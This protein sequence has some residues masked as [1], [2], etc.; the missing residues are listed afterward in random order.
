MSGRRFEDRLVILYL[1][2]F[3]WLAFLL[4][5]MRA[6]LASRLIISKAEA[7]NYDA[8]LRRFRAL[9][10][11]LTAPYSQYLE[12]F[13]R[14][15]AGR[16]AEA[17]PLYRE[18]LRKARTGTGFPC[19]P[20]YYSLGRALEDL[21]R[22]EE[23]VEFLNQ[24]IA[25]G[26]L[27]GSSYNALA[28]IGVAQ[29]RLAE[30]L[31]FSEQAVD[32]ACRRIKPQFLGIYHAVH[33]WIL[34][35][36]GRSGDARESLR[37]ALPGARHSA[38]NRAWLHWR[39]GLALVAL[40]QNE[41]AYEQ[42]CIGCKVDPRG[43]LGQRCLEELRKRGASTESKSSESAASG[44]RL[45]RAFAWARERKGSVAAALLI[46][47]AMV[48]C[49]LL[50][51]INP[52]PSPDFRDSGA[53]HRF[54][55]GR[56]IDLP[57]VRGGV[58]N[59]AVSP[60]GAIWAM[61]PSGQA[62]LRWDGDRW[63]RYS[64]AQFGA[65]KALGLALRDDEAWVATDDGIARFDGRNW[66]PDRTAP[67]TRA[68]AIAAGP[69]GV[70][71]IDRE[72]NLAHFDGIG[73]SLENLRST[74]AG[75]DWDERLEDG[76]LQLWV[77][78]DGGLWLLLGGLWRKDESGWRAYPVENVDWDSAVMLAHGGR[79][80]WL[81]TPG[82]IFE[83]TLN[84][85]LGELYEPRDLPIDREYGLFDV[86]QAEGKTWLATSK[87]LLT[88]EAGKWRHH[89]LPPGGTVVKE[90]AAA[91]DG[92][93]WVVSENRPVWRIALWLA[94]PF[95]AATLALLAI[96]TLG[97]V[98]AGSAS[99]KRWAT[100]RAA[101]RAAGII[102]SPEE[103][104]EEKSLEKRDRGLFWKLPLFLAGFPVLVGAPKWVRLYFDGVWP[105]GP[106]WV[107]WAVAVSPIAAVLAFVAVRWLR[108]WSKP[109]PA[110]ATE[111][112]IIR[113]TLCLAVSSFFLS[114]L[115]SWATALNGV[116]IA[117]AV[118][119]LMRNTVAQRLT[120]PLLQSG[121]YDRALR[122]LRWLSFPRPT[123][124][125]AFQKATL[126]S[127]LARH[128]EV[129]RSY[130]EAFAV[131]TNAKPPFRNH[132][133]LCL[134]YTLTDLGRYE[135][136]Q[137]CLETVI[138]LGDFY[139]SA[140]LGIADLLLQQSREPGKALSLVEESMRICSA[141]W[142]KAE[143]MGNKAW[144]LALMGKREEMSDPVTAALKGAEGLHHVGA[145]ASIRWRVGKALAAA[146]RVPEAIEQ[147]RAAFHAD[148][149]GHHGLLARA[150]L[151]NYGAAL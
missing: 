141:G 71:L 134:G 37:L 119:V 144:A 12:A 86:A 63:V 97:A 78:G 140:R 58:E 59:V 61:S 9:R 47:L 127:A 129:E 27:T 83:L 95:G 30:A 55:G 43:L 90:V 133:L 7:G 115:P 60:S 62:I 145:A 96:G 24:A 118:L 56:W 65:K 139:G 132:L 40:G 107:S 57:A 147:F 11:A 149:R 77:A 31:R 81:R 108:Q 105:D 112:L 85:S 1:L 120:N 67:M 23:A 84:N 45:D 128:A 39:V 102:L 151:A 87:S 19:Q 64:A 75:A 69:S 125:M 3:G 142:Y 18:A 8:A 41:D 33:A 113:W 34:A 44:W 54:A 5:G 35:L 82:Y 106:A 138:D 76:R 111:T 88:F 122:R 135:E 130:R 28:E 80:V 79:N 101:I 25:A 10:F 103:A 98:W 99:K 91:S 4:Y 104:A 73:W 117:V 17:E 49:P 126:L 74:P 20:L 131:S 100:H 136:A 123:A 109:L 13:L 116:A 42:F 92:S 89:G 137:R 21:G 6:R 51:R 26:D 16:V 50:M 38:T 36:E 146:E 29:G 93:V 46:P 22:F 53:L 72:A 32:T 124:W 70:W 94:P 150:E 121:D 48:A 52:G 2:L 143:R 15:Y 114:K 68:E 110:L 14:H 66:R 148:P